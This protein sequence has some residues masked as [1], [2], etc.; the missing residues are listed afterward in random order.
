MDARLIL[1]ISSSA[2]GGLIT[3]FVLRWAWP[4]ISL[5]RVL[6]IAIGWGLA[7][8]TGIVVLGVWSLWSYIVQGL[9]GSSIMFWLIA[10]SSVKPS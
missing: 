4:S 2:L 10:R 6:L 9:V 7:A 5:E 1:E 3:G 8:L